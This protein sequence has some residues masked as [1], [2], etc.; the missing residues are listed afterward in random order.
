MELKFRT[1]EEA[2]QEQLNSF[3]ALSPVDRFYSFLNLI[4][5]INR[6]GTKAKSKTK[7]NFEIIIKQRNINESMG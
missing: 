3:L 2:N 5:R 4:Q 1:K 6:F 7:N